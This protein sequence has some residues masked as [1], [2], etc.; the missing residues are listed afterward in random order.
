MK[1]ILL[2]FLVAGMA[3]TGCRTSKVAATETDAQA[4]LPGIPVIDDASEHVWDFRDA[5][6]WILGDMNPDRLL[7]SPHSSWYLKGY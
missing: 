4:P 5:T 6:T 3:L 1:K 2:L 7:E